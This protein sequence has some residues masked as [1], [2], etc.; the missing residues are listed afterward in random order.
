MIKVTFIK[1][2]GE[3]T[4]YEFSG[5][6][7]YAEQGYDIVCSAV[8]SAALLTANNITDIFGIK[9]DVT[10]SDGYLKLVS[11]KADN[12]NRLI[13]GLYQF[14]LQLEEQYPKDIKVRISEDFCYA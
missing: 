14:T 3:F 1:N 13:N 5:H 10:T 2:D 11:D 6:S 8:S 9:A 7:D 12:T 4:G